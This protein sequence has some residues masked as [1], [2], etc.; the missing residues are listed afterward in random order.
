MLERLVKAFHRLV[1]VH[2]VLAVVDADEFVRLIMYGFDR[3]FGAENQREHLRVLVRVVRLKIRSADLPSPKEFLR[4]VAF[5]PESVGR[6]F[7]ELLA[8]IVPY[9]LKRGLQIRLRIVRRAERHEFIGILF[10]A[11]QVGFA[12]VGRVK[13][14]VVIALKDL[15]F[16]KAPVDNF[17]VVLEA[18][19]PERQPEISPKRRN[20][21]WQAVDEKPAGIEVVNDEE[22]VVEIH[23]L[24]GDARNLVQVY[25]DQAGVEAGQ[26][27]VRDIVFVVD[28]RQFRMV[29][30]EPVGALPAR[31]K[32]HFAYPWRELFDSPEPIFQQAVIPKPGHGN[33]VFF[34]V[35]FAGMAGEILLPVGV[36][37]VYPRH[38]K[39]NIH[40]YLFSC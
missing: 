36:V 34:V 20:V 25:F 10:A 12:S 27:L 19:A 8:C 29:G 2:D 13:P 32:M 40:S 24:I 3:F 31:H 21:L 14:L 5:G 1:K 17:D 35:Y 26:K 7:R 37:H 28:K 23:K 15:F 30:I 18:F 4:I 33:F 9:L 6:H 22:I 16:V 11:R 38:H 39:I